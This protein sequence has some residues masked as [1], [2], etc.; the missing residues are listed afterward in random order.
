MRRLSIRMKIT[1]WFTAALILVM[2]VTYF[3]IL[4]RSLK[5]QFPVKNIIERIVHDQF[6]YFR[7]HKPQP[8]YL[9]PNGIFPVQ[10]HAVRVVERLFWPI[11]RISESTAQIATGDDLKKRIA[12]DGRAHG[13]HQL[14]HIDRT[15]RIAV[16]IPLGA[17]AGE[18][19]CLLG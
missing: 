3:I 16:R 12:I 18:H 5:P 6:L 2:L 9:L 13:P 10:Q 4:P 19:V 14:C 15:A 1:L 17:G 8:V 7:I 11:Q